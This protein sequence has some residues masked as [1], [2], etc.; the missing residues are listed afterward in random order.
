MTQYA[1]PIILRNMN[2]PI[3]NRTSPQSTIQDNAYLVKKYDVDGQPLIISWHTKDYEQFQPSYYRLCYCPYCYYTDLKEDFLAG[4]NF[5]AKQNGTLK[6]IEQILDVKRKQ[7]NQVF[8]QLGAGI[9]FEKM[10]YNLALNIHL[11]AIYIHELP[12]KEIRDYEKLAYLY[13]ITSWIYKENKSVNFHIIAGES[14]NVFSNIF[15]DYYGSHKKFLSSFIE[16]A[17]MIYF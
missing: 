6:R 14:Y 13:H 3:C 5:F 9:E 17:T 2:C 4:G 7:N 15:N 16:I 10:N 1:S 11:L 8:M 12:E